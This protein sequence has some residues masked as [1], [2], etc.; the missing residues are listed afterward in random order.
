[1][2]EIDNIITAAKTA[3]VKFVKAGQSDREIAVAVSNAVRFL[4]ADLEAAKGLR[5]SA[6]K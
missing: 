2:N 6:G 3:Y 5:A 4:V 1:M